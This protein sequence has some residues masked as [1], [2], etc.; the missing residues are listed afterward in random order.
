LTLA[1]VLVKNINHVIRN[2]ICENHWFDI[3]LYIFCRTYFFKMYF[4]NLFW[5]HFQYY[6]KFKKIKITS[7]SVSNLGWSQRFLLEIS[8]LCKAVPSALPLPGTK[9]QNFERTQ[10]ERHSRMMTRCSNKNNAYRWLL[11]IVFT[12]K[13]NQFLTKKWKKQKTDFMIQNNY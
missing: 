6:S 4:K 7:K 5:A 12:R 2:N 3:Q 1:S 9:C 10:G 11:S 8:W 13:K